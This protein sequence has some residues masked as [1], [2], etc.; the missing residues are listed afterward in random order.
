MTL[1][2]YLLDARQQYVE[3][4]LATCGYN[5]EAA[6]KIL[7]ISKATVYRAIDAKKLRIERCP[8]VPEGDGKI[9]SYLK[10]FGVPTEKQ[11]FRES[12]T[13]QL[14]WM[15]YDARKNYLEMVKAAHPDCN[16][17]RTSTKVAEIN[18]CWTRLKELMHKH[19]V[20]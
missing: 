5:K 14:E 9:S 15:L 11:T 20:N 18:H 10:F 19:G 6:A 17:G 3:Q 12:D 4:T 16:C 2:D 1:R 13:Q 8:K 7:G